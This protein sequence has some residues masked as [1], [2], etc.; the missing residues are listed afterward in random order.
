MTQDMTAPLKAE[1]FATLKGYARTTAR[2]GVTTAGPMSIAAAHFVSAILFLQILPPAEFGLL[3]FVFVAVPPFLS[4]TMSL[5]GASLYTTAY[6]TEVAEAA[7]TLHL[8]ANLCVSLVAAAAL[9][10]LMLAT[11]AGL[12]PALLFGVYGAAMSLRQFARCF[13]Y[14]ENRPLVAAA[15]DVS[16]S[17]DLLF[18]VGALFLLR[19][20]GFFSVPAIAAVLAT[21][22]L[23]SLAPFG[24]DYLGRQFSVGL[25]GWFKAYRTIWRDLARWSL[26]GVVCTE[27]TANAHAYLVTL[28]AGPEAFA[29]L[30]VGALFL[31]PVSLCLS[32][33]PDLERASMAK[34]IV[35]GDG[36]AALRS[37]RAFRIASVI[38]WA[39]TVALAA[40]ILGWLPELVLRA[41]YPIEDVATVVVLW[42]A[43]MAVRILRT[44]DGVLLQAAAEF[45]PLALASVASA[46]ASLALTL[47]LLLAF[48]PVASLGGIIAGEIV[49]AV[50]V[51][52]LLRDWRRRHG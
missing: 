5:I 16:Y 34:G 12:E 7:Q 46:A 51:R 52:A 50:R 19:D 27:M 29:L 6:R 15:S 42:A 44:P 48:G 40:A 23:V 49:M 9:T 2:Y 47:G 31:R 37:V 41:H 18:G 39:G 38:A 33:L 11:G 22:A 4:V 32:A 45:R 17:L 25:T 43:I 28:I 21:A 10:L 14:I 1:R 35:A 13:A 36:A 3:S 30:A 26:L 24:A 8:K 20:F